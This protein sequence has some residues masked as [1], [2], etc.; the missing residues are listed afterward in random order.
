MAIISGF[1]GKSKPKLQDITVVPTV[2][3]TNSTNWEVY[4]SYVADGKYNGIGTVKVKKLRPRAVALNSVF[5]DA[6][7]NTFTFTVYGSSITA[8]SPEW[9]AMVLYADETWEVDTSNK[10]LTQSFCG[11]DEYE[12]GVIHAFPILTSFDT[13]GGAS[14]GQYESS[15]LPGFNVK[16]IS[17]S[18]LIISPSYSQ[19]INTDVHYTG[20]LI[21]NAVDNSQ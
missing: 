7:N 21:Y 4:D 13:S 1:P 16:T 2:F 20:Y 6:S 3:C 10:K 11:F 5:Y 15:L 12:S 19:T 8:S 17:T 9:L 18:Q 14:T